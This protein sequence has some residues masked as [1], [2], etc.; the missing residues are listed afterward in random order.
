[1]DK[2]K[3]DTFSSELQGQDARRLLESIQR[4]QSLYIEETQPEIILAQ[5]LQELLLLTGSSAGFIAERVEASGTAQPWHL[6]AQVGGASAGTVDIEFPLQRS[7]PRGTEILGL[8]GLHGRTGGYDAHWSAFLKPLLVTSTAILL[9]LRSLRAGQD[10]ASQL[11]ESQERFHTLTQGVNVALWESDMRTQRHHVSSMWQQMLGYRADELEFSIAEWEARLHPDDR[12][13]I[14]HWWADVL[15][16]DAKSFEREFRLRHRDGSYRWVYCRGILVRDAEGKVLRIGGMNSDIT[17]RKQGDAERTRLQHQVYQMQKMEVVGKL[18]EGMANDY[19]KV[20]QDIEAHARSAR[21]GLPATS[22]EAMHLDEILKAT[23]R[24][25][26]LMLR[27][28]GFAKGQPLQPVPLDVNL[29]IRD[30]LGLLQR[31]LGE[32]IR[33]DWQLDSDLVPV[34]MDRSALDQILINLCVNA[35]DAVGNQGVISIRT[36]NVRLD[37]QFQPHNVRP[38]ECDFVLIA[39]SDDGRAMTQSLITQIFE[40]MLA[41]QPGKASGLGL[42]TVYGIVK[43]HDGFIEVKSEH[44]HGSTF[45]IYLPRHRSSAS[46]SG[47]TRLRL[48]S[49]SLGSGSA[50]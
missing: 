11:Q 35:R 15:A 28:L 5:L 21:S 1:M 41:E 4:V 13:D 33:L 40:P 25:S 49:N 14:I 23:E 46:S 7:L 30:L 18:A 34:L 50:G 37:E 44:G 12:S 47:E 39:V 9:C 10:I 32:R 27:L 22:D 8:V 42:A 31:L 38:F 20:L 17:A 3:Q 2:P 19:H 43:Q 6:L 29:A 16:G 48:V 26:S 45:E 36:G 24:S